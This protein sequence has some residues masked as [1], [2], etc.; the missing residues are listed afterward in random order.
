MHRNLGILDGL[1]APVQDILTNSA[2]L[3]QTAPDGT[4]YIVDLGAAS[5][6][7]VWVCGKA[8]KIAIPD[9][10]VFYNLTDG[11]LYFKTPVGI[12]VLLNS[13]GAGIPAFLNDLADVNA[14]S[15]VDGEFLK[16]QSGFWVPGTD[17]VTS[18]SFLSPILTYE[19]ETGT[20]TNI[21]LSVL[22]DDT[23]LP[24]IVNGT[25]TPAK[26]LQLIR[27]DLSVAANVD[28]SSLDQ[29]AH[30]GDS[31]IHFTEASID[32]TNIQNI[33]TNT[34]AQIDSHIANVANP[35]QVTFTQAVAQDPGTDITPAEAETLTDGSNADALHTH[36]AAS[37]TI[38]FD[39]LTDGDITTDPIQL[40]DLIEWDGTNFVPLRIREEGVVKANS[41]ITSTLVTDGTKFKLTATTPLTF[42]SASR[43]PLAVS[44]LY[45]GQTPV[46]N[47]ATFTPHIYDSATDKW[48]ENPKDLQTHLWRVIMDYTRGATSTNREI[49]FEI[50]N[51]LSGFVQQKSFTM[52]GGA[53][54]QTFTVEYMVLT[55]ADSASIGFGYEM[56][57]TPNGDDV[58]IN[59]MSITRASLAVL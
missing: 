40:N 32:H 13:P 30:V 49:I 28:L 2:F 23:N 36:S 18:L 26:F 1:F 10:F 45:P 51:P 8:E 44:N 27:D 9:G 41:V 46:A 21:D 6:M 16:F 3:P 35:H 52:P 25:L 7:Y 29:S 53:A 24:R 39:D 19:D 22:L 59:D 34:H 14:P 42:S 20:P 11:K 17:T 50:S 12:V 33:G 15:P 56:F 37:L 57:I 5:E 31:A 38:G 54:F 47:P 55:I 43:F 48:L 58:T 4:V